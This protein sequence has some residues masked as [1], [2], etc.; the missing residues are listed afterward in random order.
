[1]NESF[2]DSLYELALQKNNSKKK[3]KSKKNKFINPKTDDKGFFTV[4]GDY[5]DKQ[6]SD[7]S[8]LIIDTPSNYNIDLT[9]PDD[10]SCSNSTQIINMDN[11][12]NQ[13]NNKYNNKNNNIIKYENTENNIKNNKI[14]KT[15][16]KIKKKNKIYELELKDIIII[17]LGTIIVV[18][19]LDFIL[20]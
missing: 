6:L 13:N 12:H 15:K 1:M 17:I 19:F 4:Q 11:N 16:N 7:P 9:S 20:L 2:D 5:Y 8:S 10:Q 14:K 3:I 18:I